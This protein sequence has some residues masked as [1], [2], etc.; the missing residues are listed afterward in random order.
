MRIYNKKFNQWSKQRQYV[1]KKTSQRER[2]TMIDWVNYSPESD[3]F[4]AIENGEILG[5]CCVLDCYAYKRLVIGTYV[6]Q[7][8][9]RKGIGKKLVE[10]TFKKYKNREIR[11][12]TGTDK[13]EMFYEKLRHENNNIKEKMIRAQIVP[14]DYNLSRYK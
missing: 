1:L 7:K 4:V 9:R 14:A 2:G 10:K 3:T 6:K 12:Y 5:W 11:C 13:S 8:H